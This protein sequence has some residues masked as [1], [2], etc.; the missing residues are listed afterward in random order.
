MLD[1]SA[2]DDE[3]LD[4]LREEVGRLKKQSKDAHT[5]APQAESVLVQQAAQAFA[6]K[7]GRHLS[8]IRRLQ[9]LCDHQVCWFLFVASVLI[10]K[11]TCQAAQIES[12]DQ[13]LRQLKRHA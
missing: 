3:L 8:E 7:E 11:Y 1:K 4:M 6:E 10:C 2:T 5:V 9:R 12:Q 13:S